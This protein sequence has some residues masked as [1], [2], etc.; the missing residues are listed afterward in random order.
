[1]K[2]PTESYTPPG[3]PGF[4]FDPPA[5]LK[6]Q[7]PDSKTFE[8]ETCSLGEHTLEVATQSDKYPQPVRIS[9]QGEVQDVNRQRIKADTVS[10]LVHPSSLYV[11]LKTDA[12]PVTNDTGQVCA[13]CELV[14]TQ[15]DGTQVAAPVKLRAYEQANRGYKPAMVAAAWEAQRAAEG[16][17]ERNGTT[18]AQSTFKI[19]V[20]VESNEEYQSF[21]AQK[22]SVTLKASDT[23][24]QLRTEEPPPSHPHPLIPTARPP[25]G[26]F[27]ESIPT[28]RW[29][30]N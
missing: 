8:G 28:P 21:R 6:Y 22:V 15:I 1:M 4:A 12:M 7:S 13:K 23:I 30:S 29:Q 3:H 20:A 26:L 16:D 9:V 24:W 11:G 27:S 17:D 2:N 5:H 10:L 14:V 18:H 19:A 25:S